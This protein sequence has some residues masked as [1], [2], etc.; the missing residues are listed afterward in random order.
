MLQETKKLGAQ[1]L[2][3]ENFPFC[4]GEQIYFLNWKPELPII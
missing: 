4:L 2:V 1:L 3:S